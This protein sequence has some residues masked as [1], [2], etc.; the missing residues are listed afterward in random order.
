[1][2]LKIIGAGFPR[3]GTTTL[4]QSLEML[5]FSKAYHFKDLIAD[6][7]KLK[8]WK[9]IENTGQTDYE[10]LFDGCQASVDFPG[11]PYYK[12]LMKEYPTAK[13][14]LTLRDFDSWY[15]SNLNTIWKVPPKN[16]CIAFM[17]DT[18]LVKQFNG[19]F[20]SREVAEKVF[21]AHNN[22][23]IEFVPKEHLLVYE[24]KNGWEPLCSF[25]N[26]PVP[27]EPFPHLNKKENFNAMLNKMLG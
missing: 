23:V 6:P 22:E 17:R 19:D 10:Q 18:Y 4:K 24:V 25:L 7:S 21:H 20:A 12:Q 5:G 11:Y 3:T 14:V 26:L 1:M 8:Y 13:V 2:S 15:K 9:E 16:D 27:S